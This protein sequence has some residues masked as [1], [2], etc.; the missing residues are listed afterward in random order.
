M[1]NQLGPNPL[2]LDTAG[3]TV[4]INHR[5]HIESIVWAG[6]TDAA[7]DYSLTDQNS[8]LVAEDNGD[9]GL[10]SLSQVVGGWVNGLILPTLDSGKLYIFFS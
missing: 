8:K 9:V 2:V 4:L 1:S 6:Y 7:H 10:Q 5:I 3:A